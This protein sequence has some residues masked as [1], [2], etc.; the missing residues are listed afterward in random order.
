MQEK[1]QTRDTAIV[2][3]DESEIA[4]NVSTTHYRY[5]LFLV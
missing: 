5:H 4:A 3:I 2:F 1:R